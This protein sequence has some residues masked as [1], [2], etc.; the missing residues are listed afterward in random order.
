MTKTAVA[1]SALLPR[2]A[3]ATGGLVVCLATGPSLTKAD[4]D[5]VRGKATVVVVNDAHRMAPWADCLYSSDRY[6]WQHH[7]GVPSFAGRK[8]TIEYS[9]GRKAK[10][11]LKLASDMV[12]YRLARHHG[13]EEQP[14]GLTTCGLNSG[15]AAI[16]LAYHLGAQRIVLLGYDMGATQ[17]KRHFFGDHP[18]G[19]S[20]TQNFPGW[21]RACDTM[22]GPFKALG[23]EVV[24]CS[25]VTSLS[26]FPRKTLDEVGL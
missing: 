18:Q 3:D 10:E 26:A 5:R 25:R 21:R 14:D 20:N 23:V 9:Q 7:R 2:L 1:E 16:N 8:A 13:V 11:L 15:G 24:N 12:F 22:S 19:L 6:W 4:V 17:G